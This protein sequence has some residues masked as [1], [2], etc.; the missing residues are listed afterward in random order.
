[1]SHIVLARKYRPQTLSDIVGQTVLVQTIKNAISLNRLPQAI[2]LTGT[3]G[4]GKTT[5]A[6]I[7]AKYLNCQ[8]VERKGECCN[9]CDSCLSIANCTH[10]DIL[11]FDAA[12]KTSVNDIREIIET[13]NY[14]PIKSKNKFYIIDE[15]HMLSN[16]AFNALLKTLEEPPSHV[17]FILATTEEHKVP[18]TIVSRTLQFRLVPIKEHTI[19]RRCREILNMEGYSASEEILTIVAKAA[20]GSMRDALTILEGIIIFCANEDKSLSSD[21][22]AEMLGYKNHGAI[23]EAYNFLCQGKVYSCLEKL[24]DLYNLGVDPIVVANDLLELIHTITSKKVSGEDILIE[25]KFL[26]RSWHILSD[27]I[28]NMRTSE[29]HMIQLE[30]AIIKLGHLRL[31][32]NLPN[33]KDSNKSGEV[34]H[35]NGIVSMIDRENII[36]TL[37]ARTSDDLPSIQTIKLLDPKCDLLSKDKMKSYNHLRVLLAFLLDIGE[38]I[39]YHRLSSLLK[40]VS[41]DLSTQELIVSARKANEI[42]KEVKLQLEIVTKSKW[43]VKVENCHES[44]TYV[45][46]LNE[47]DLKHQDALLQTDIVKYIIDKFDGL[48]VEKIN[49]NNKYIN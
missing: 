23:E 28:A 27:T 37:I 17:R 39:L 26:L 34:S 13:V 18:L 45:E 36:E 33:E 47:L 38:A 22:A 49:L 31:D 8:E 4:I 1:M 30:M 11:E 2:L 19:A 20:N 44:I 48:K 42:V 43:S 41:L 29:S 12:S 6:R 21:K 7:I 46:F 5:T 32:D 40:I 25:M 9:I 24:R 16:S 3:R 15:V 14:M 10:P 35:S